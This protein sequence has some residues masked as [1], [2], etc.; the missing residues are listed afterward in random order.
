MALSIILK[1]ERGCRLHSVSS[2]K[3]TKEAFL[4]FILNLLLLLLF[5]N[6][7]FSELREGAV[8]CKGSTN[9]KPEAYVK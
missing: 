4:D 8:L 7:T 6:Y 5:S 1:L 9:L 3:A 2:K